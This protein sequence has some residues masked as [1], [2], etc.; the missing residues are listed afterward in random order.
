MKTLKNILGVVFSLFVATTICSCDDE[1]EYTPAEKLDSAQVYFPSTNSTS[2]NL[3]GNESSFDVEIA[4]VK[5]DDA[6]T[7]PLT[8]TGGNGL[9]TAPSSVSFAQGAA[10]AVVAISYDAAEIGP[11]NY[12][13]I[14]LSIADES[15]T[16]PYGIANYTVNVGIPQTYT[17]RYMGNYTYVYYWSGIDPGLTLYQSDI[18]PERWK[19]EHWGSD[20]D[21][22]FTWDQTTNGIL[23]DSQV[24]A[25]NSTYGP[26]TVEDLVEYTGSTNY[27]QSYY[28]DGVFH[29][30]VIY[31]V[32]AGN[33]GYGEETFEVTESFMN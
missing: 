31:Y 26:V 33:F 10:K 16:T 17:A 29:F 32:D 18:Y 19:I 3:A 20:I 25:N 1:V 24:C 12:M 2:L 28:A 13:D 27:G 15:M 11:D 9:Y 8:L 22:F 23:V 21:F 6:I 30:A 4:R 7:V 14:T 5:T